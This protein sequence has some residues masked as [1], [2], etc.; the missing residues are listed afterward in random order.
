MYDTDHPRVVWM[1][2]NHQSCMNVPLLLLQATIE[3]HK[4][5]LQQIEAAQMHVAPDDRLRIRTLLL[6]LITI[7]IQHHIPHQLP[8]RPP[9]RKQLKLRKSL[10]GQ[11]VEPIHQNPAA[12][13]F[14]PHL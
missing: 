9:S 14:G 1:E 10:L 13:G 3:A 7:M 6:L 5:R 2:R 4:Q 8:R 11:V 12:L